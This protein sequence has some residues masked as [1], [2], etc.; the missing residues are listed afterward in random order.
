M[1]ERGRCWPKF[2]KNYTADFDSFLKTLL[3]YSQYTMSIF[4]P[5]ANWHT[6]FQILSNI[7]AWKSKKI[8][9]GN[10]VQNFERSSGRT[11][12]RKPFE[13]EWCTSS[14][15]VSLEKLENNKLDSQMVNDDDNS[16]DNNN[17]DDNNNNS[18]DNNNNNSDDNNN[19]N[20]NNKWWKELFH[21]QNLKNLKK[22]NSSFRRMTG[23]FALKTNSFIS[24][25]FATCLN[26][27]KNGICI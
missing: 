25:S 15:T 22:G 9:L 12:C 8:N 10:S 26:L 21:S 16:N 23:W 13:W 14:T 20:N 4:K 7:L 27:G 6:V 19:R 24:S 11:G 5:H 17:S 2:F 1:Y 3:S 18:D